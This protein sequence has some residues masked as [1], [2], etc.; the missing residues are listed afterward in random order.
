MAKK[1][2]P[3][4][5]KAKK[6]PTTGTGGHGR[7]ALE[8]KGP[9][10]KAEDRSWHPAGK[11]KAAKERLDT[12]K[13]RHGSTTPSSV[14]RPVRPLVSDGELVT[15]RNAVIEALRAKIPATTLHLATKID[16]DDRVRESLALANKRGIPLLE[17]PRPEL[18]RIAGKDTVHQGIALSVP[19]Y[20]YPHPLELA[21]KAEKGSTPPI[22]VALDG[23]TDPRNLGAIV[24]SVAAFGGS[25]VIVPKRRSAGVT[26]TAWKTSAG[27]IART[28]VALAANLTQTLKAFQERGYFVV[29]L[30]GD[31]EGSVPGADIADAPLVIVVGS[32]GKGLS[33]LVTETCDLILSIPISNKAESLNAGIAASVVLYEVARQRF[34]KKKS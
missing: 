30:D 17:I 9:T 11:R 20:Q 28:P 22:F 15:G 8:G 14:R 29:G 23:I 1:G 7:R 12:A 6:P 27:A 19:A 13:A 32:E 26:A 16:M 5:R 31:A 4:A 33:K 21:E 2:H 25:G 18:D 24:R 3:S 10:P 34:S